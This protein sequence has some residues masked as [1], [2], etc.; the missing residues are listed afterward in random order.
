MKYIDLQLHSTFSEGDLS[1]R[2]I[3]ERAGKENLAVISLTDHNT[4]DGVAPAIQEGEK[5]K[6]LVIPGV[7]IYTEFSGKRLHLLGYNFDL[8]N[9]NLND[10]LWQSQVHHLEWAKRSLKKMAE[11]GFQI[12]FSDL[13]NLKSKYCGFR[14]LKTIVEKYADNV[15][16]MIADI[17]PQFGK[18][19]LF[20]FINFY[21]TEGKF[22]HIPE[23]NMPI[24]A[25]EAI[26]AITAAGGLPVLAHPGQQLS[27]QDDQLITELKNAGLRGLEVLS[28][29]HNWH[30]MEHYQ[31]LANDL[32]LVITGGTDFHGDLVDFSL[33]HQFVQSA[34]DYFKVPYAVYE[35]LEKHLK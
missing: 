10:L 6:I 26:K 19:T 33:K 22:A 12:D 34:W 4:I 32:D 29:Y 14:H 16:R 21:F 13:E 9:K 35:N 25:V 23:I 1:P 7:E 5:E 11:M 2:Q 8:E 24:D 27:W 17:K 18:P 28:P 3:I 20:E 15:Q 30:Q 31:K